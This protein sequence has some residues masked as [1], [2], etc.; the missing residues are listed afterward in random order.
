MLI[1]AASGLERLMVS[2][3]GAVLQDSNVAQISA[4]VYY[5]ANVI[6]KLTSNKQFQSKF[7]SIIFKQ[8]SKDFG[9]YIDAIARSKP[10]TMHH[11]YEWNRVGSPSG[12]L[13]ELNMLSQEGL[14][15]RIGH[16]FN[17]SRLAVPSKSNSKRRHVFI[18]KAEVMERGEPLVIRP[19]FAER[20]VF[21]SN[22]YTVFM[23]KGKSVTVKRP[24]GPSVKNQF[25]LAH[26]R[27]FK[28]QLV[29]ESIKRS[30]FQQ[31][32]NY[33][34][35][36]ALKLPPNIKKVQYTFSPNTLRYQADSAL[37]IAFGGAV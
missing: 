12:R 2:K 35:A 3:K 16:K 31:I 13:F 20:L 26:S 18:N 14:S 30:G 37:A 33:S 7:S 22:G 4:F 19:R 15:F 36:R 34:M 17:P 32:F 6:S 27:F 29:N 25:Y 23:P 5:Q 9:S 24:G 28:G 10:K 21:E 8:I 11:V 1:Q